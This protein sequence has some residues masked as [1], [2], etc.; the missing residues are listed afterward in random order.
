M[1]NIPR[2]PMFISHS[3]KYG[4]V[5]HMGV[6]VRLIHIFT[7]CHSL[8]CGSASDAAG[9]F[10][11]CVLR[12]VVLCFLRDA[13]AAAVY[14][15]AYYKNKIKRSILLCCVVFCMLVL[16]I[17]IPENSIKLIRANKQYSKE[18]E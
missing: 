8:R 14:M 5:A 2:T 4:L 12:C 6:F 7:N 17:N 9:F 15:R 13:Y 1:P 11:N 10:F 18:I 3:H 16:G